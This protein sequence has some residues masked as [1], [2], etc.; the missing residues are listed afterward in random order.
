M[1]RIRKKLRAALARMRYGRSFSQRAQEDSVRAAIDAAGLDCARGLR[2]LN[3]VLQE[4]HGRAFDFGTDS[5]HWLVFACLVDACPQDARILEIGTF[6]GEF[7]AI[8]GRLFPAA[9]IS[10]VDLPETDPILRTTY[11]RAADANYRRFLAKRDANL[12]RANI[13]FLQINSAFLLDHL[14][15]PFDLIWADGGHLYPEVAWDIAAAHHLCREGGFLLC[16]DV[17][18][19]PDGPRNDY[20]S[21]DSYQVLD[22]FAART[23]AVLHLFLKR[24]AFKHAAVPRDRKYIAMLRRRSGQA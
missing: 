17:I 23:G 14:H 9:S 24:C 12:A 3:E 15:A 2:V 13:T 11:N 7:T 5:V 18:P 8:L 16:D 21:P 1:A 4:T 10:T 19:A 22:Y 20:V 6:D